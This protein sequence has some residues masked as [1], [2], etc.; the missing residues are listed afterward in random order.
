MVVASST[1]SLKQTLQVI[2]SS[3]WWNHMASF[4]IIDSPMPLSHGCS[5]AFQILSIAWKMNLLHAKFIC[6]HESKGP[7]IYSYNPYTNQ[8]PLPWQVEKTYRLE[9]NHPWTLLVRRYQKSEE[10][11]K[12]L[13]FDKTKDLGGYETQVSSYSI[14]ID[15]HS[16][17]VN[18][19]SMT[20]FNGI[21][22]R[23]LIRALNS[24]AKIFSYESSIEIP[25]MIRNV[26]D[27][28][29]TVWYQQN[30]FNASMTYPFG[31]TGMVSITQNRGR[32]SQI[33]KLF[34]VLDYPSRFGVG[35][36]FFVTFIF[37]KFFLRYSI[38]SAFMTIV[39]LICNAALPN[40]PINLATRI[41]LSGLFLFM[42]TVEA[43]YQG[44]LASLL[45]KQKALPN[46]ETLEELASFDYTIYLY[47]TFRPYFEDYTGRI[48]PVA[49]F[50]CETYVLKDASAACLREWGYAVDT[51]SK[52]NLHPS[53]ELLT[54]MFIVYLIREDWPI[55]D[56]LN[57]VISRLVEANIFEYVIKKQTRLTISKLKDKKKQ[58]DNQK[59]RVIALK[60]LAFA[61][62][63]LGIGL[64]FSTVI[65]IVEVIIL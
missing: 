3:L 24:T 64:A 56:R 17:K 28:H 9:N 25:D 1:K 20:G 53:N 26:S 2:K 39:R 22:A 52:L 62:A 45:T 48:V 13:D 35:I 4:L 23:Y 15:I 54:T 30:N 42:L 10:I 31:V 6:H 33:G 36:V 47:K 65:F 5:K 58:E 19:E 38:T 57:T 51:A 43:I 12:E 49:E 34:H 37:F 8:A 44:Q 60:D 46:V 29:L 27:I 40:L 50:N 11:C 59:F 14:H 32:L 63:I 7:L 61:F 55:E 41:F 21:L 18:L 16:S